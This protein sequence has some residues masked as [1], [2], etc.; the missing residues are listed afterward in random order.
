MPFVLAVL[1][2]LVNPEF[3]A[4]LWREDM[5]VVMLGVSLGLMVAGVFWMSRLVRI[6][7]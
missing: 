2:Y 4:L 5:G 3:M 7:V 1:M 6:K